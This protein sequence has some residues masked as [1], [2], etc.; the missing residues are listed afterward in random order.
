MTYYINKILINQS[1]ILYN[2][3]VVKNVGDNIGIWR[4]S[5]RLYILV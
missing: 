2:D 1:S 3:T 4:K 5:W